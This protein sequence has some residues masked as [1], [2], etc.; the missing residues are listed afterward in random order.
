[1]KYANKI[2][3]SDVTPY[4][5]V[6]VVS[7]KTLEIRRMSA[8]R[9]PNWTPDF[10]PGG[11]FGTVINQN[12]QTWIITSDDTAPVI[13]IRLG[14]HGWKDAHRGRYDLADEPHR[15]YDFNF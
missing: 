15:F 3:Y 1:M 12:S 10:V 7:E 11:F 14:K 9:D 13:R 5:V 4:E 6:R 8:E 2:G